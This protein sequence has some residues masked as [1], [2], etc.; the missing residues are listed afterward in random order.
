ME[1]TPP[2]SNEFVA[3]GCELFT[4][5]PYDQLITALNY[6]KK[7][8]KSGNDPKFIISDPLPEDDVTVLLVLS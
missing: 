1:N 7:R 5:K 4:G 6:I 3:D 8:A 2:V